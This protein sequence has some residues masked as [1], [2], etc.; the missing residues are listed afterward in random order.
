MSSPE[1]LPGQGD[2][3]GPPVPP[4]PSPAAPAPPAPAE[5]S[6]TVV[7]ERNPDAWKRSAL[8][9]LVVVIG[10]VAVALLIQ[11]TSF[12]AF[13]IPSKSMES[14]LH[15]GDR[16]LVNKWSYRLHD[17]NRGDV[18]VFTK[19]K[20][21]AASNIN[22][23]IKRVIGLPGDSVTIANNHVSINGHPLTEPY[24]DAGAVSIAV[25]GKWACTPQAPCKIPKGQVWVMG[26]NRTDSEDSRYFGP[27]P[28]S[29]VV[30]RAFFRIWP[31]NRIGS[32]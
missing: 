2:A 24:L 7:P 28:E 10:A 19:P 23:L 31:L 29:S 11:A 4:A 21:E 5:S 27:I 12:Q 15:V 1:P 3:S 26:D 25:P 32:L 9:W 6:A 18:V 20:D 17:L 14:T 8:E 16:V 22:D 30:G 13:F